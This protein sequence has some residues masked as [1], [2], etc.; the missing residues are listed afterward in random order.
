[1]S[2]KRAAQHWRGAGPHSGCSI[3]TS[4]LRHG[5]VRRRDGTALPSD[6]ETD[7]GMLTCCMVAAALVSAGLQRVMRY[8]KEHPY[9]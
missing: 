9:V 8:A 1:M 5:V 7:I 2:E 3:R 4:G 6:G